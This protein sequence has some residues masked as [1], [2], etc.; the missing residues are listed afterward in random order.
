MQ[1]RLEPAPMRPSPVVNR[2]RQ[3]MTPHAGC[4]ERLNA[5]AMRSLF[6]ATAGACCFSTSA[7]AQSLPPACQTPLL[8]QPGWVLAVAPTEAAE[9][10][11]QNRLNPVIARGDFDGDKHGDWVAL[12]RVGGAPHLAYCLGTRAGGY[13]MRLVPLHTCHDVIH[14]LPRGRTVENFDERR[15]E[16][17]GVDSVAALCFEKAGVAVVLTKSGHRT[18]THSD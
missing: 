4:R 3:G 14:R 1:Q 12:G 17:L 10:A 18:F 16:K 6:A 13:R 7:Q 11:K 5:A 15:A 8:R 2:T 9:W